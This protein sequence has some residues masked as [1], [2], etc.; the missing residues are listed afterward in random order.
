MK[1]IKEHSFIYIPFMILTNQYFIV[2]AS[3]NM[4]LGYYAFNITFRKLFK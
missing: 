4:F 1:K 3:V 2:D